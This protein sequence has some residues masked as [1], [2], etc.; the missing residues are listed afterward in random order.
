M[1]NHQALVASVR[2]ELAE[3]RGTARAVLAAA[4]SSRNEAE[5][6]RRLVRD[7]YTT[8]LNQLAEA[9]ESTRGDIQRRYRGESVKLAGH[10]RG[11]ATVSAAG[12]AGASWRLW[13]PTEPDPGDSPG[14]LR[15]GTLAFDET[16]GLPAL[17]PLLGAAHLHLDG[18]STVVADMVTAILLRAL[19]SVRPGDVRLTV[20]D[21]VHLG[22]TLAPF[23][24]L[25]VSFV[26]PG[27][28]GTLLDDLVEHICR[29]VANHTTTGPEPW[30]VVV[31]L[32]D[33]ATAAELTAPQRAQLDRIV[34]TGVACGVHL[35]VRG[36]DLE[37]HPTVER[38][39]AGDET[40]T[41]SSLGDLEV[42]LDPLP[43]ADRVTAH[44][45]SIADRQNANPAAPTLDDLEP[46]RPWAES[47]R[48]GLSAPIGDS[49]DGTLVDVPLGDDPPHA[50]IGGPPGSGKTNLI[51]VWLAALST[52]YGPEELAFYLLDFKQDAAFAR[53]APGPRDP[54]WLP[55][56]RLAGVNVAGDREFGLATLRHLGEELRARAQAAK[57]CGAGK[58]AELRTRD[59]AGHWPRIV[60]VIDEFPVLL[61]GRDAA[62]EEAADL[63]ED[64]A[65]RGRAQGIHLVLASQE[66]SGIQALWGRP[67]LIGQFTL[68]IALPKARRVLADDN[69]AAAV[70]P[71]FHAVVNTESGTPGANRV[72]RLPDAGDPAAWR[73]LQ[74]RL[75]R[76]RPA[77]CEEP[78]L[79]DGDAVPRLPSAYRRRTG[80]TVGSSPGAVLGERIDVAAQPARLRL[81]RMAGRNLA[82]AG[83]RTPEACD[84]LAAAALSLAA[85]GPARFT[86]VCLATEAEHAAARLVADLPDADRQDTAD[87][88]LDLTA[89]EVPRYL[90]GYGLDATAPEH[91]TA[92]HTLLTDGPEQR[93][94]VLG[95][96][97][98]TAPLAGHLDAI[99]A[100]V[101]LDVE[102]SDLAALHPQTGGPVWQPRTRRALFFDR[103]VHRTPEVII[104]YE[105]NSDHT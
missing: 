51:H 42:R 93:V 43:P 15:I 41:C 3:A 96:W 36:L 59:P 25:G 24:P 94:H 87:L 23:A 72:V 98:S 56:L 99:G 26:G 30:R 50:L 22:G 95:W 39:V 64:L 97:R 100:W 35:V 14:L 37:D 44:C 69:L 91:R 101:A 89:G 7:A 62:A 45:R 4:E 54:S 34:R 28:L 66:V 49:T 65:R 77:G 32:A 81:G 103:S 31:L 10:L 9:R 88:R 2:Q 78:R 92:L 6:R 80:N 17:I 67:G 53:Y 11:L 85:Q 84:I 40:V 90:I 18:P 57:R 104:P 83:T 47:S 1:G 33:R 19:G 12:A 63:L 46:E 86:V 76:D 71:R 52:R 55:Q 29:R 16:A 20:Y 82:V 75:W 73:T 105:V 68:R 13:S 38:I 61:T 27:G 70:I 48:Y 60:A 102:A 79:F 58:L 5:Q 74:R 8:C 21:P